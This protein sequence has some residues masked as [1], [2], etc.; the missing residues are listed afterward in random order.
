VIDG[1]WDGLVPQRQQREA[2][3]S[4]RDA[5][6]SGDQEQQRRAVRSSEL[7]RS[8]A[9]YAEVAGEVAA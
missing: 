5:S 9:V 8:L 7:A 6:E 4:L 2:V 3:Q 1:H